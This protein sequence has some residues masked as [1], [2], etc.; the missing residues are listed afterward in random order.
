M[1]FCEKHILVIGGTGT[2]GKSIIKAILPEKPRRI[3]I[4]SRDEHKQQLLQQELGEEELLHYIIGDIRD[5]DTVHRAMHKVDLV[6]HLAAMKRVDFSEFNPLETV[7]T[8]LIGTHNV[9][10]AA[11][12]QQVDKVIFT[13]S[14]KAISPTNA[15]GAS[16]LIAERLIIQANRSGLINTTFACVRFGNVMGS[17]GSVIP[18][19]I[20]GILN[21]RKITITDPTMTR[22]MMTLDQATK[23]TIEAMK[24]AKGGEVFVLKMPVIRIGL[25]AEVVLEEICQ[26]EQID[27]ETVEIQVV[28]KRIGEK[29]YEELMTEEEARKAW[30]SSGMFI[31]P[32]S[33]TITYPDV[34]KAEATYYSSH[35]QTPLSTEKLRSLLLDEKLI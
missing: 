31:I 1:Y 30:E 2:I 12:S 9:I 25:L 14:D 22:F 24:E 11:T 19:F 21:E 17:R 16:K 4:L 34:R 33:V 15:Y 6:F 32:R 27:K 29:M 8:N 13:S 23:L 26:R 7:K 20:E 35:S 28:G 3:T 5:F 10:Q 18:L